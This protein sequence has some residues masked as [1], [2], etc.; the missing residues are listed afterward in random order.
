MMKWV[1]NAFQ[2]IDLHIYECTPWLHH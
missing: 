2:M 1:H